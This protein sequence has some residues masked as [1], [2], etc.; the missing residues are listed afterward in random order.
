MSWGTGAI[1]GPVV[2][3]AFS[4]SSATWRWVSLLCSMRLTWADESQAFYINLPLAAILSPVYFFV[5][6]SHNPQP[7][8]AASTKIKSLDWA[9]AILNAGIY[10]LFMIVLTFSGSQWPWKSGQSIALWIIW[11]LFLICFIVQQGFSIFTT[12]DHRLFPV[13]FL[14][15]RTMVL[16]Y[17]ATAATAAGNAIT[18]YYIP[19]FF[20]FTRGDDALQA[21]VRLL[22]FICSFVFSVMFAGALLPMVK[23]YAPWY[24][25]GGILIIVGGALLFVATDTTS[26]GAIYGFEALIAVGVGITFQNAYAVAASRVAE[27]DRANAIG[28]INVAQIG[29]IAVA[30]AMGGSLFQNLGFAALKNALAQYQLPDAAIWSTLAGSES[31]ILKGGDPELAQTAIQTV[32]HT[33]SRLYGIVIGG[34]AAMLVASLAMRWE[35]VQLLMVA[36]G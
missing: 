27:K 20:Q 8:V 36:G 24:T 35:K 1:L 34:G 29:T 17:I 18:L 31:Q 9:G 32:A 13:H 22:P 30:L 26:V 15:S 6:P 7:E 23:V 21:A 5:N 4:Q 10:V 12:P 11:G 25:A 2:G 28:F 3:G 33:I 19:L 14:R 16:L